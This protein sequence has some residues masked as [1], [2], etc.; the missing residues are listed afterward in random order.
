MLICPC[1]CFCPFC[2]D[3]ALGLFLSLVLF[4]DFPLRGGFCFVFLSPLNTFRAGLLKVCLDR[5]FGGLLMSKQAKDCKT[6]PK[7]RAMECTRS[8]LVAF[9]SDLI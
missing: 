6:A 8:C 9:N 3:L 1:V 4:V 7:S 5:S 2:V